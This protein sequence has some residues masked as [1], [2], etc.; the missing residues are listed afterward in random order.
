MALSFNL[1]DLFVTFVSK[2]VDD[3]HRAINALNANLA[4]VKDNAEAVMKSVEKS[5]D[6]LKKFGDAAGKVG[7]AAK[8]QFEALEKL[9][10]KTFSSALKES[11]AD[12]AEQMTR[13]VLYEFNLSARQESYL[14][15]LINTYVK[16]TQTQQGLQIA[17][18]K[19]TTAAGYLQSTLGRGLG[20]LGGFITAGI[21]SSNTGE[22]L[23]NRL[24]FLSR[25]I[26]GL[27]Q[28]EIQKVIQWI[29][30]LNTWLQSLS[31][32]Q[33]ENL[34][35][36]IKVTAGI[37]AF[38]FALPVAINLALQ[39]VTAARAL[40]SAFLFLGGAQV[41]G[42]IGTLINAIRALTITQIIAQAL[43]GP[44]GWLA[45]AAGI[46]VAAGAVG[47][48]IAA[49]KQAAGADADLAS[50]RDRNIR[51]PLAPKS[52]GFESLQSVWE[53]IAKSTIGG[54]YDEGL[55]LQRQ[56]ARNVDDIR[57]AVE[58]MRPAVV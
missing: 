4:G 53:R 9:V 25:T 6:W 35:W 54:G 8:I 22:I 51:G 13:W 30:R 31:N 21:A 2:G 32:E 57:R 27:F 24:G 38:S 58:Q 26:A 39:M 3:V 34:V 12:A 45:L 1:A 14:R 40:T 11:V 16:L 44:A 47:A 10:R 15:G 56:T 52:S 36:W 5:E 28:P 43:A 19:V 23:A 41:I 20:V 33:K 49:T 46:L 42:A 37:V 17:L 55:E 50:K 48:Y 7:G 29:D 18:D